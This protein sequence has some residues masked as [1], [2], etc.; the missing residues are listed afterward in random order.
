[1][2]RRV[3]SLA[4]SH[5]IVAIRL[6]NSP[7]PDLLVLPHSILFWMTASFSWARSVG[8]GCWSAVFGCGVR[9]S[10]RE[11]GAGVVVSFGPK[12]QLFP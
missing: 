10:V 3:L 8:S 11:A 6:G 2:G 4:C 12:V 9:G 5:W 7:P 1:M